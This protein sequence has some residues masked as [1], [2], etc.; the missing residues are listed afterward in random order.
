MFQQYSLS[1]IFFLHYLMSH[2]LWDM[3]IC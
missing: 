1:V 2:V 3:K